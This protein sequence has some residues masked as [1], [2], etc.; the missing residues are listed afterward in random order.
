[1]KNMLKHQMILGAEM[2]NRFYVE[3][4]LEGRTKSSQDKV[5]P[6]YLANAEA[7][8]ILISKCTW[9]NVWKVLELL[10]DF[11]EDDNPNKKYIAW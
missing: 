11:M 9:K 5:Q 3:V 8:W 7:I 1:M 6:E 10:E 2:E 4:D